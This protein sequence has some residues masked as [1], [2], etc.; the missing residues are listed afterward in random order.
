MKS[1]FPTS[2]S[3][4]CH[5]LTSHLFTWVSLSVSGWRQNTMASSLNTKSQLNKMKHWCWQSIVVTILLYLSW[6]IPEGN[7]IPLFG[8]CILQSKM[9]NTTYHD[10]LHA[11]FVEGTGHWLHC[12]LTVE[13]KMSLTKTKFLPFG[14]IS[15]Y[16]IKGHLFA[17]TGHMVQNP[18]CY[19]AKECGSLKTIATSTSQVII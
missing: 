17:T 16:V 1:T 3:A 8:H 12:F 7:Y 4:T 5:S 19:I 13:V 6:R 11:R 14:F 9:M 15:C 18:T 2:T 10:S